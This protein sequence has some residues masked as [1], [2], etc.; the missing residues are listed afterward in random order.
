MATELEKTSFHF[1][2][3]KGNVKARSNY[4]AVGLTSYASKVTLKTL[5]V[6][7]SRT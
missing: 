4:C 6:R 5:Q 1:D 7:F 2:P 3:Q